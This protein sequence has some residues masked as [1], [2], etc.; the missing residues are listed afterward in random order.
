[1]DSYDKLLSAWETSFKERDIET[2]YGQT[3]MIIAGDPQHLC[4]FFM[5]QPIILQ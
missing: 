4:C 2:T 1:M 3:H 5:E